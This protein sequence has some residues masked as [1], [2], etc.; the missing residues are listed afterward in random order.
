MYGDLFDSANPN[1][2]NNNC[3]DLDSD[4]LPSTNPDSSVTCTFV[5]SFTGVAGD[6]ETDIAEI[7]AIDENGN[8]V[9]DTDDAI[10]TLTPCA[11]IA[12]VKTVTPGQR[13]A[14]GGNFTF[15]LVITN[16]GPTDL[17]LT[18]L[19]DTIYGDLF[20]SAN[21]NVT[22]N[23]CDD[24][25]G[26]VLASTNPDASVTCT[27]VGN[28]TGVAGDTETDIAEI[29]A[30]DENG[31]PT[32]D[33]DDAVVQLTPPP[34]TG[35]A[36]FNGDGFAD[37]AVGVPDEDVGAVANAGAV[38][39]LYGSASG[40]TGASSQLWHQNSALVSDSPEADDHFGAAVTTGD[41]N[42]DGFS[43]L[44]VGA[45]DEDV[46]AA[47]DAGVAHVLHG[48]PS[49]LTATAS[50]Y[51]GQNSAGVVDAGEA[52][53]R[54]GASLA[55]GDLDGGG[56]SDVVVGAPGESV[57][58]VADAGVVHV[59][60]GTAG[61][62][63]SA[64]NQLWGQNSAGIIDSAEAGDGF[65]SAVAVGDFTNDG[66][67]ELVIGT[68]GEDLGTVGDGGVV[69]VLL[70]SA[71]GPT[72]TGSQYWS[73]NSGSIIDAV[74]A[75]DR[76]GAALVA[77][78]FNDDGR[79][80]LAVG[81][82][83]EDVGAVADAGAVNVLRGAAAGLTATGNLFFEQNS[84]GVSDSAETGDGFAAALAAGDFD[85]DGRA[86]LAVGVPDEDVGALTDGGVVHVLPGSASGLTATGSQYWNQNSS[87]ILEGI[88]TGDRFGASLAAS[89]FKGLGAAGL[90]IGAPGESAGTVAGGGAVNVI[91]GGAGGLASAGN[92]LWTQ[93][94]TGVPDVPETDDHF[95]A[96]LG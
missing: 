48:S 59:L 81:S 92:Q 42:D 67:A 18:T 87:G 32:D 37:L 3:D 60:L 14:P 58:T 29:D 36:D 91:Y 4:V 38:N 63:A 90:A 23:N 79:A 35:G 45:P 93:I 61:G 53:D 51:W 52:G 20:D 11:D 95:G 33:N 41:F 2:T 84:P 13:P 26:D 75:G 64:G 1:V 43:D 57:G 94:S 12:I 7:D 34:L 6:T 49:G 5:G 25:E 62:L 40:L 15:T 8:P 72:A 74:E 21:P 22:N 89:P 54:F 50:Q 28:F 46:G 10:V 19:V 16:N 9:D 27:F 66:R 69:H 56:R 83:A 44:A 30:I 96:A 80:D 76:F 17:T 68:P 71:S 86:D 78:D 31:N 88:E 85:D 73:Q 39:V 65:G 55:A 47:V 77:G 24:L 82:P 70:G